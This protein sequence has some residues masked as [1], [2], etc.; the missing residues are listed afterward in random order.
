MY[1]K[2]VQKLNF[3]QKIIIRVKGCSNNIPSKITIRWMEDFFER[4]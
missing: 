3:F 4:N 2:F 1:E